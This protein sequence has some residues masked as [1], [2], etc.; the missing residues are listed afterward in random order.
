M[1]SIKEILVKIYAKH[2][3]KKTTKWSKR[4]VE[5]QEKVMKKLISKAKKTKFG[6]D[7]NFDK[8][9]NYKD[10]SKE[11]PIRDYEG[12]KTY[13]D[14]VIEGKR[15]ILWPGKPIYF[16]KTSG[17]TSGEKHIPITRDSMPFHVKGSVEATMH[18]IKETNNTA[19]L[20][21][22]IIFFIYDM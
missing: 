21:K 4:P 13:I 14:M 16:A 15:N 2:V 11:I 22:K 3:V 1:S 17:T 20:N 5:T 12:L 6:K 9:S 18:Y 7:H 8:I 10:F 19:F